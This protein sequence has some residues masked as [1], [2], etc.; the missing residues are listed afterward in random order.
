MITKNLVKKIPNLVV[1]HESPPLTSNPGVSK[2]FWRKVIFSNKRQIWDFTTTSD[3][4]YLYSE[5][6]FILFCN[7]VR[8]YTFSNKSE[9]FRVTY[10][11]MI[12]E[13]P[14]CNT[15]KHIMF[16]TKNHVNKPPIYYKPPE[17]PVCFHSQAH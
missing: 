9:T 13:F 7:K 11:I 1:N 3:S 14:I 12:K 16:V 6:F 15:I 2:V 8:Q 10:M 17:L 5:A 4:S